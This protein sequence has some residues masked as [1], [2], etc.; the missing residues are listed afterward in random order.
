MTVEQLI[1]KLSKLPPD[2]KVVVNNSRDY[3]Q[4]DEVEGLAVG[5]YS[6]SLC[7]GSLEKVTN[8]RDSKNVNAVMII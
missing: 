8:K 4:I 6:Y 5:D 7:G 1:R 3:E 2:M